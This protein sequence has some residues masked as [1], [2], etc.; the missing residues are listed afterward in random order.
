MHLL[1]ERKRNH[2][3]YYL[4]QRVNYFAHFL[5]PGYYRPGQFSTAMPGFVP[6]QTPTAQPGLVS[7][8]TPTAQPGFVSGNLQQA[9]RTRAFFPE[10]WVWDSVLSG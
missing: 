7:G 8:Q 9:K 5:A 3:K 2:F 6:G 4:L 10:T 1:S